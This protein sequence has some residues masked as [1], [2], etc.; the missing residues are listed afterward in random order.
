M[1]DSSALSRAMVV[2]TALQVVLAVLAYFSGWIALHALLF[3]AMMLSAI[4]GYLYAQDVA[5][6]YLAGAA[7]GFV[8]GGVSG[9]FGAAMSVVLGNTDP[10]LFVQNTLIFV[11]TGGVGGVFGQMAAAMNASR[12]RR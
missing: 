12:F 3:G 6:G 10:G 9:L 8:A 2:G 7:G 1:I 4:A 11:L 5:K